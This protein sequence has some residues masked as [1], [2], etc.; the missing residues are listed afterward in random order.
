M[1]A[2]RAAVFVGG[3]DGVL[4]VEDDGIRAL[5]RL[6]VPL[7]AIGRAEQQRRSEVEAPRRS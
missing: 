6:L 1:S 2:P 3:R 4:E 7:R 5:E